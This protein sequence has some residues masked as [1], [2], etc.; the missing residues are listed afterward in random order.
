MSF[1]ISP[2]FWLKG[3]PVRLARDITRWKQS[4]QA[5]VA[6]AANWQL[7]TTFSEWGEGTS[8]EPALEWASLSGYGTYLDALH[9]NG[10]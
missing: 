8:V 2:G 9:T 7:V 4:V 10:Q 3:N 6:S 1:T 5:M